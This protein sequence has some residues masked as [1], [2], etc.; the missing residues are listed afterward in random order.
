[1]KACEIA[2]KEAMSTKKEMTLGVSESE[3]GEY[4]QS[5]ELSRTNAGKGN[6]LTTTSIAKSYSHML[7]RQ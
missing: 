6:Y 2:Q 4:S 5:V 1:M 3:E 7:Q